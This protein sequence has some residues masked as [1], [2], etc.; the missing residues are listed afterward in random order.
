[1]TT[2]AESFLADLDDLSD[3]SGDEDLDARDDDVDTQVAFSCSHPSEKL[4]ASHIHVLYLQ[5][6]MS[7]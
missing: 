4:P 7:Q 5:V 3:A 2:L 1:M 6:F